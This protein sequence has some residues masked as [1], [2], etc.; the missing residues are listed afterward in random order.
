M[1]DL[2][3]ALSKPPPEQRDGNIQFDSLHPTIRISD[4]RFRGVVHV[5]YVGRRIGSQANEDLVWAS[6][7]PYGVKFTRNRVRVSAEEFLSR[8]YI[9]SNWLHALVNKV[10][11]MDPKKWKKWPDM[12]DFVRAVVRL[13]L[14]DCIGDSM[15][16]LPQYGSPSLRDV[17]RTSHAYVPQYVKD[18]MRFMPGL[19]PRYYHPSYPKDQ[20]PSPVIKEDDIV[21][22]ALRPEARSE[23]QSAQTSKQNTGNVKKAAGHEVEDKAVVSSKSSSVPAEADLQNSQPGASNATTADM[24]I[25]SETERIIIRPAKGKAFETIERQLRDWQEGK[26]GEDALENTFQANMAEVRLARQMQDTWIASKNAGQNSR[27]RKADEVDNED[28]TG[29]SKTPRSK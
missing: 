6:V 24:A 12:R 15:V 26:I 21:E 20:C 1:S 17:N 2:E 13:V 19:E 5:I 14:E 23:G 4:E 28:S 3:T 7:E 25:L 9:L 10:S 11:A 27:K 29:R 16:P 8:P 22:D 18:I